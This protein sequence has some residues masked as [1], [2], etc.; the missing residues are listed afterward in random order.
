MIH[1]WRRRKEED[2]PL[3]AFAPSS[4]EHCPCAGSA[5]TPHVRGGWHCLSGGLA[6]PHIPLCGLLNRKLPRQ[7]A[8]Y[9]PMLRPFALVPPADIP[10]LNI[11]HPSPL[12]L[13]PPPPVTCPAVSH[14]K[15]LN[16]KQRVLSHHHSATINC[17][18][19]P[20]STRV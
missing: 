13:Q 15:D 4:P 3:A 14:R 11:A 2:L 6:Q 19:L 9:R 8:G 7:V 18:S 12:H 10:R 5:Q 1:Q 17:A 20:A 16:I